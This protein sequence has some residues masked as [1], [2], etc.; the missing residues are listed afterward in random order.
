MNVVKLLKSKK[1]EI[2]SVSPE[3][4]VF[5]ALQVMS[6]KNIGAV[7]VTENKKLVGILSE[8]D[9]ARKV[10]LAGKTSK[11]TKVKEIMTSNVICVQP[12]QLIEECMA[13]MSSKHIR[14]L[15]VMENGELAGI[16]SIRDVV[17]AIISEKEFTIKQLENYI[18]GAA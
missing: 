10:I 17:T 13:I 12:E 4:N 18:S 15:P 3:T 16:I 6:E 11:E 1:S 7:L 5:D 8:R 14:H 2:I 9:Y